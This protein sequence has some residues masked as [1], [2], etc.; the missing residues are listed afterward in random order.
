MQIGYIY[1]K[2]KYS[3]MNKKKPSSYIFAHLL[4]PGLTEDKWIVK[5]TPNVFC[6]NTFI[7]LHH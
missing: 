3:K 4:L 1:E 6:S 2:T 7:W 5:S